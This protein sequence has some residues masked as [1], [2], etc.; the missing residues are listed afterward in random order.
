MSDFKDDLTLDDLRKEFG[1]GQPKNPY[2]DFFLLSNPFPD[3]GQFIS[4]I[5]V[6]QDQIKRE[7]VRTLREFYQDEQSRRMMILGST[8]AGKTNLLRFFE[9]ELAEWHQPSPGEQ[10][11]TDLFTIFIDQPQ[12]GYFEIHRQIISQLGARFFREFFEAVQRGKVNLAKLSTELP[13][14]SPELTRILTPTA[15]DS[16][17]QLSLW[18]EPRNLRTLEEWL[19]GGKLSTEVKKQLG[20]VSIEVGKSSTIAIK[21]LAD[22]VKIFRYAKLFK[23]LII[24][25]DEFEN[26]LSGL[27]STRQAQYA[28]DLRNLF[29]SLSESVVFVIATT[30]VSDDLRRISPALNRRLGEGVQIEPIPNEDAALAYAH[31]YIELGRAAFESKMNCNV[32]LPT[33][34]PN[35]D[36]PYYP[37]TR[38]IITD[39]YRKIRDRYQEVLPG[40]LLPELNREL[41]RQV[42]E[43]N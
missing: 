24:L 31:A 13:G 43:R 42:Y 27:S 14:I 26:I 25:F 16:S 32:G 38:S 40:D 41:Y 29:D 22:L 18:P 8:G 19:Q 1:K 12:G 7:F 23:G 33:N 15:L 10:A 20:G 39:I 6:N 35:A 3:I 11:I 4:G 17:S 36:R 30:P 34:Y 37:L 9:Q 5:C 2:V 28:Q 21:F